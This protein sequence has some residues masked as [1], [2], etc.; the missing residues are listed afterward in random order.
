MTGTT[1]EPR[2]YNAKLRVLMDLTLLRAGS[3]DRVDAV[4]PDPCDFPRLEV[5]HTVT[6]I[7]LDGMA[8]LHSDMECDQCKRTLWTGNSV[9]G[10]SVHTRFGIFDNAFFSP[11]CISCFMEDRGGYYSTALAALVMKT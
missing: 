2:Q 10:K 8:E 4:I 3:M 7:R 1:R 9:L 6:R 5:G 11:T